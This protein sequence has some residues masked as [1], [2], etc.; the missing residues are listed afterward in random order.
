MYNQRYFLQ[1]SLAIVK[2]ITV[3]ARGHAS[4]DAC[5]SLCNCEHLPC[6]VPPAI[7][8]LQD[9]C[10]PNFRFDSTSP[11]NALLRWDE[12]AVLHRDAIRSQ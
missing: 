1:E 10:Q 6:V 2:I 8:G 3:T 12:K 7:V 5:R 9:F 4:G 11:V